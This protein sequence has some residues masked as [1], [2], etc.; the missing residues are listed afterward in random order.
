VW[1]GWFGAPVVQ[2]EV[3]TGETHAGAHHE[4][5]W[6]AMVFGA[7]AVFAVAVAIGVR[8]FGMA[9]S[10]ASH[11]TVSQAAASHDVTTTPAT[12]ETLPAFNPPAHSI[13]VLP[14]V[15][16]SGDPQ[17]EYF[18]D[19]L[20]EELLNSL[21][22]ISELKVA[23]A[24]SLKGKNV[25]AGDIARRANVGTILQGSVRKAGK[26]VRITV[27]LVDATNGYHLWSQTYDRELDNMFE[28][29][30]D[31]AT[32]V[33]RQLLPTLLG[34]VTSRRHTPSAEAYA[35]YLQ[36][37]HFWSPSTYGL[38]QRDDAITYYEQALQLDEHYA[39]AMVGLADARFGYHFGVRADTDVAKARQLLD[40]AIALDPQ[41]GR[42]YINR[43]AIATLYDF[44]WAVADV[45]LQ[46]A[47]DLEPNNPYVLRQAAYLAETLG[48]FGESESLIRKS[49]ERD[50][51]IADSYLLLGRLQLAAGNAAWEASWRKYAELAAGGFAAHYMIALTHLLRKEPEKALAE[52]QLEPNGIFR[53]QALAL[54]YHDL[55]RKAESDAVLRELIEK[56]AGQ[57]PFLIAEL[58]AYRGDADQAMH[59]LEQAY[60]NRD[61]D[62]TRLLTSRLPRTLARD[63]RYQAFLRKMN[64]PTQTG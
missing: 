39:E 1:Q 45:S 48:R 57:V 11:A 52:A 5:P 19:G 41:L 50:P 64:L 28:V 38:L 24:F 40:R 18:S 43:A 2:A 36:G 22:R 53:L 20:A 3:P 62:L 25:E 55:H 54:V 32:N 49:L 14:F 63:P 58:H 6:L 7:V 21:V 37:N 61:A 13:A 26:E 60:R 35:A 44:D 15:N 59:W 23:S 47:R 51:L 27:Q 46:R 33:V 12:A 17:Q 31:I 16:M 4:G 30:G 34:S 56:H 8:F 29:Q 10:G 42:P 9:N